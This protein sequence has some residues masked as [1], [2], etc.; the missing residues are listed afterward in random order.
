MRAEDRRQPLEN[1]AIMEF[2]VHGEFAYKDSDV[3]GTFGAWWVPLR[4]MVKELG[5]EVVEKELETMDND[6]K[7]I[8]SMVI[9]DAGEASSSDEEET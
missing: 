5:K 8:R 6:I 7:H 9:D 4:R 1:G 3:N 2:L